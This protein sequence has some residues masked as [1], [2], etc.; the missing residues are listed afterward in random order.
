MAS[1][2][3]AS[4]AVIIGGGFSGTMVA[5]ELARRGVSSL[6]VDGSG[7]EGRGTA[8]ST[9][10]RAHLLNVV[11]RR[12]GAWDDKPDDFAE[13]VAAEGYGPDDFVPRRRYGEYICKILHD[14]AASGHVTVVSSDA[15]SATRTADGW[16]V[17]LAD[18]SQVQG[19]AH[20]LAQGNQAPEPPGLARGVPPA[21]FVSDPWSD[22]GREAVRRA[23]TA[24]GDVLIIG[25]GLTMVDVVL[26]LDEA[27]HRGRIVALSRRGSS[28][29]CRR[30]GWRL[31]RGGWWICGATVMSWG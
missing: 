8:Y 20:V 21:L 22:A 16:T 30:G 31:L 14:A 12:M 24:G 4:G 29:W 27:A 11:A 28:G 26:S 10:E 2:K 1:D 6:L 18:G 19:K 17:G 9:A 7:R 15:R 13:A 5:A 25:T 3:P 23:A